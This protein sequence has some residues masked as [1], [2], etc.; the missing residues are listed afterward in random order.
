[1]KLSASSSPSA[2]NSC[3][4]HAT[5]SSSLTPDASASRETPRAVT[6]GTLCMIAVRHEL[7][8]GSWRRKPFAS[9]IPASVSAKTMAE[10]VVVLSKGIQSEK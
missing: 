10:D 8:R 2:Q 7:E 1:M 9:N 5:F 4:A 6:E 3:W